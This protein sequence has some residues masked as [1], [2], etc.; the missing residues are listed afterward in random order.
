ML[1]E[2]KGFPLGAAGDVNGP[3]GA[4]DGYLAVFDGATGKTIKDGGKAPTKKHFIIVIIDGAGAAITTGVKGFL[5]IPIALTL[6]AWRLLS[7]DAAATDG[8]IVIDVWKDTYANYPPTDADSITNGHEPEI[9]ASDNKAEDSDI[10]D[11]SDVTVDAG[12]I[13]GFN[14]DSCTTITKAMLIIEAIET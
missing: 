5:S 4:T 13:L 11:W 1:A 9:P 6:Q 10:S 7:I 14:V 3:A 8:D 2:I 12:D